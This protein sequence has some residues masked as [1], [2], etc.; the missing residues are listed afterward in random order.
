MEEEQSKQSYKDAISLQEDDTNKDIN[1]NLIDMIPR[2][3]MEVSDSL[4]EEQKGDE[5]RATQRK[6]KK[7]DKRKDKKYRKG[8]K[9]EAE[10][11]LCPW[12]FVKAV[13][14]DKR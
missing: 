3:N 14:G 5:V 2:E 8:E 4:G 7:K 6:K 1:D 11:I 12:R 9:A 13:G 10:S